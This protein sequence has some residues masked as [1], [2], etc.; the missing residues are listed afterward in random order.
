[1]SSH[2][3][4]DEP[5]GK[6]HELHAT[7]RGDS[8]T[9]ESAEGIFSKGRLDTG[10]SLLLENAHLPE[11]GRIL[12][13][14]CGNGVVGIFLKRWLPALEV[15]QSDVTQKA[16]DLTKRNTL[17]ARVDT[18]VLKSDCYDALAGQTF[19]TILVNPP[20]AA[21]K[22]IIA[23]M[24]EEAPA[25]LASAGSLQLV[26]MTNKGGKSYK[27]L[28]EAAFGNV[29]TIARGSGFQVYKSMNANQ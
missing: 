18:I 28:M 9:L 1:M 21:G 25:H 5:L 16:V 17:R 29:E 15:V 26:A 2:Y 12:D 22:A 14:G 6:T 19:Q 3:H 8:I 20:R 24:I 13:L 27:A 11:R 4:T 23:R 7:A 10:T